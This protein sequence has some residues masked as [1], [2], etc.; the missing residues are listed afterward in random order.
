MAVPFQTLIQLDCK[1][2]SSTDA[3]GFCQEYI[4]T[5]LLHEACTPA[6][7]PR[8]AIS[9]ELMAENRSHSQPERG[10]AMNN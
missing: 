7:Y 4:A 1:L 5:D 10:A 3:S 2:S 6:H 8:E 9:L